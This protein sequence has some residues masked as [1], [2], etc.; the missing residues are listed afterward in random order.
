M[1]E[2][3][4]FA[5]PIL[6]MT[7]PS[8]ENMPVLTDEEVGAGYVWAS[9]YY[10]GMTLMTKSFSK[11]R[12][13]DSVTQRPSL[14]RHAIQKSYSKGIGVIA[15]E[16]SS[17]SNGGCPVLIGECGIPFDMGGVDER[18]IFFG[19]RHHKS[20]FETGDFSTC[21]NALNR[22]MCALEDA[23]V[24]YTIWC[25]QPD[26]TN[27]YGDGWNGEDLSLFSVDQV[28]PGDGRSCWGGRSLRSSHSTVSSSNCRRRDSF[29]LCSVSKGSTIQFEVQ[30]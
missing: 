26:N 29:W 15:K 28:V 27:K 7:D 12:G 11:Y 16:A 22:T 10:D 17:I 25:Y 18:P 2:A 21:T 9:H 5:E 3:I 20:A 30:G 4:I 14:G 8:K 6:D 19:C 23:Q 13:M 1:P 24:S